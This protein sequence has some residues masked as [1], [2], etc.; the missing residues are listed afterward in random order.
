M[1]YVDG[2]LDEQARLELEARLVHEEPLRREVAELQRLEVLSRR[3]APP[4]LV[5]LEWQRLEKEPLQRGLSLLGFL[6]I[7]AGVAAACGWG[8]WQ[9]VR[10]DESLGFKL[11]VGAVVG[12]FGL[13]FLYVLRQRLRALPYDPYTEVKH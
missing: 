5:E 2:E 3:M 9:L 4:E 13:L 6:G 10:S 12:G 11:I 8:L 1:A 7:S